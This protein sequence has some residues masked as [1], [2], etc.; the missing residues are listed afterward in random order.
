MTNLPERRLFRSASINSG[1]SSYDS[2]IPPDDHNP[3]AGL[4]DYNNSQEILGAAAAEAAEKF[5]ASLIATIKAL[6]GLDL[7]T[8]Q[9]LADSLNTQIVG[10]IQTQLDALQ[11]GWDQ[12]IG[13]MPTWK[14]GAVPVGALVAD[15]LNRLVD[16]SFTTNS[17]SSPS[18]RWTVDYTVYRDIPGSARVVANGTATSIRSNKDR[19]FRGQKLDVRA[20]V[21][22]V[23]LTGTGGLLELWIV[24]YS[25][26]NAA[27]AIAGTPVLLQ[28]FS[29]G[30][31]PNARAW[32]APP[33][34][35]V[36]RYEMD[37]GWT[38]PDGVDWVATRLVVTANATAGT[39]W[40]DE[41]FQ[42]PD[43]LSLETWLGGI[44][45]DLTEVWHGFEKTNDDF[46]RVFTAFTDFV[47]A[48]LGG[49]A[50]AV[51]Q[52][53][54]DAMIDA[55][56]DLGEG[57]STNL[58]AAM[59][60]FIDAF[61]L[62]GSNN[63]GLTAAT[64]DARRNINYLLGQFRLGYLDTSWQWVS[65]SPGTDDLPVGAGR[66]D[67]GSAPPA[68]IADILQFFGIPVYDLPSQL[69]P[70]IPPAPTQFWPVAQVS[71]TTSVPQNT[72]LYYVI[73]SVKGGKES[74]PSNEG[75]V[76]ISPSWLVA[77]A[78]VSLTWSA[79][80]G[81]TYNVYRR[82]SSTAQY[83]RIATGLTGTTHLDVDAVT[84][85]TTQ[86]GSAAAT[87]ATVI[88]GQFTTTNGNH[89]TLMNSVTSGAA[90]SVDGDASPAMVEA[91]VADLRGSLSGLQGQM[92]E[93]LAG[94]GG[95]AGGVKFTGQQ[96]GWQPGGGTNWDIFGNGSP[97][98]VMTGVY[99]WTKNG[100]GKYIHALYKTKKLTSAQQSASIVFYSA[101]AYPNGFD[102][103][104]Y[105]GSN[106]LIVR[107]KADGSSFPFCQIW[108][109]KAQFGYWNGT[110]RTLVGSAFAVSGTASG[111]FTFQQVDGN[112]PYKFD[113]V[114]NGVVIASYTYTSTQAPYGSQYLSVGQGMVSGTG[115][116]GDEFA[117][118]S[119]LQF[120]AKDAG[121][122]AGLISSGIGARMTRL[123]TAGSSI[124]ANANSTLPYNFFD[125]I[126]WLSAGIRRMPSGSSSDGFVFDV[127]GLYAC[128]VNFQKSN[129]SAVGGGSFWY[130][131]TGSRTYY[132][133]QGGQTGL[134]IGGFGI[135][136]IEAGET[137][138]PT[139]INLSGSAFNVLGGPTADICYFSVA[140]VG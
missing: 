72:N 84:T 76:Y 115:N 101:P 100:A 93:L 57:I 86:P 70:T 125:Q 41:A 128:H 126:D 45:S 88:N 56:E 108:Q 34:G 132:G 50:P 30:G 23:G 102:P 118:G 19:V 37:S 69:D 15:A 16:G 75:L 82:T 119:V 27:T 62:G 97:A 83:R 29:A 60:T 33:A 120:S 7:S 65:G 107:A 22:A 92:D 117:P 96:P 58:N 5:H 79:V 80:S 138:S 112:N 103:K 21:A 36:A 18:G 49:Q 91:A 130:G 139:A 61:M 104:T 42:A 77:K 35:T 114:S 26:T 55:L 122:G 31:S 124:G 51:V 28:S 11:V 48:I 17:I 127:G 24:P 137:I 40:W 67:L 111:G 63:N 98:V 140:K 3:L 87:A 12:I 4:L 121:A 39:L 14:L 85:T 32:A 68:W 46:G 135:V 43:G 113:L 95:P 2:R 10:S 81:A 90:G 6:T 1:G 74:V 71:T 123:S 110:T 25:G 53:R 78:R 13:Q 131:P 8:P 136:P 59:D 99:G 89:Q 64:E 133:W 109:N 20:N 105:G 94:V 73:T 116:F 134:Y 47:A 38:V 52:A 66:T 106:L 9:T 44:G 129:T 54:F